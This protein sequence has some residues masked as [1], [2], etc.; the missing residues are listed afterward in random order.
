MSS[1]DNIYT[2]EEA[3][4]K[5]VKTQSSSIEYDIFNLA[6]SGAEQYIDNCIDLLKNWIIVC[7]ID[8]GNKV[9]STLDSSLIMI[10]EKG[11][12]E[13]INALAKR[14]RNKDEY[15]SIQRKKRLIK[16]TLKDFFSKYHGSTYNISSFYPDGDFFLECKIP[17][18]FHEACWR[19]ISWNTEEELNREVNLIPEILEEERQKKMEEEKEKMIAHIKWTS[20]TTLLDE[21][22]SPL[23]LS[24]EPRN[25]D[26]TIRRGVRF[27]F[28]KDPEVTL[29]GPIH[30]SS[31]FYFDLDG[32]LNEQISSAREQLLKNISKF[33]EIESAIRSIDA[34]NMD[35]WVVYFK[36]GYFLVKRESAYKFGT[37]HFD[38]EQDTRKALEKVLD[39]I[40]DL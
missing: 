31:G 35:L 7:K 9:Y 28:E 16:S 2:L 14:I 10:V 6:Y 18:I 36:D 32:D 25:A 23:G 3:L 26:W 8:C 5:L 34:K 27:F 4:D 20:L 29:I 40:H 19:H 24:Y 38:P 13:K 30:K 37:I 12:K 21:M 39:S 17:S 22:T 1:K 33:R 11:L 15:K